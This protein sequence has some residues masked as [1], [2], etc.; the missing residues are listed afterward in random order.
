METVHAVASG[1]GAQQ[2]VHFEQLHDFTLDLGQRQHQSSSKGP[3]FCG[4]A[5]EKQQD[6]LQQLVEQEEEEQ[7]QEEIQQE[8]V[9]QQ[10]Q[11]QA[12]QEEDQGLLYQYE[13]HGTITQQQQQQQQQQTSQEEEQGPLYHYEEHGTITQQQQ[14]QQTSQEEEQGLLYHFEEHGT[15]TQ[16][17]QQQKEQ[18]QKHQREQLPFQHHIHT[19]N[20][21][22]FT[23]LSTVQTWWQH[24][25]IT[26]Q[27]YSLQALKHAAAT[28]EH[29]RAVL[30]ARLI[31]ASKEALERWQVAQQAASDTGQAFLRCALSFFNEDITP[32]GQLSRPVLMTMGICLVGVWVGV[33]CWISSSVRRAL[34]QQV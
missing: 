5:V 25:V 33:F 4:E 27:R 18:Q 12:S 34:V 10:Q 3:T 22:L 26:S 11:Q 16:Q 32:C 23:M 1:G 15:I 6:Q 17:Q 31:S 14:Q 21:H 2:S 19:M 30:L 20:A 29:S 9:L 24:G 13:E 8:A 7:L 28:A